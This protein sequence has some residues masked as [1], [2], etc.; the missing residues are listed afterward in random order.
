MYILLYHLLLLLSSGLM[1]HIL[2]NC[3]YGLAVRLYTTLLTDKE[4]YVTITKYI[5]LIKF[6]KN[7]A[8][9]IKKFNRFIFSFT[10]KAEASKIRKD[11]LQ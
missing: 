10:I 11:M 5:L 4:I 2:K 9:L 7:F 3:Y 6:L 1:C 8:K